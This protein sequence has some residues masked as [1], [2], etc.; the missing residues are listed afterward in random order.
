MTGQTLELTLPVTGMHCANCAVTIERVL[1]RLEGVGEVNVNLASE[2]AF[3][4]FDPTR[5]RQSEI[6][7]QIRKVGYDIAIARAELALERLSDGSEAQRL[8]QRLE[9]LPGVVSAAVNLAT[10]RVLLEYIP[11]AVSQREIRVEI[12]QAGFKTLEL[13]DALVDPEGEAR[14]RAVRRQRTLFLRGL[15]LTLPV[16]ALSMLADLGLLPSSITT[17]P[18]FGWSLLAL[19]TPVVFHVGWQF[20]EGSYQALLNRTANMDVHVAMGGL[21]AYGYS[22]AVVLGWVE[23][24]PFFE[25]AAVIITLIVLGRYLEARAKAQTSESIRALLG[26]TPKLARI[27]RAGREIEVPVDEVIVGD[28]VIVRPGEQ[29]PVDG[30][31]VDG[32]SS[33]DESMLTG[34]SIPVSKRAGDA[35]FA[36]SMN[37]LGAFRFEATKVGRDTALAQIVRLVQAAQASKAAIQQLAD[38]VSSVFVPAVLPVAALTFIA[39]YFFAPPSLEHPQFARAMINTVAVLVI[40]CPCAMGLATPTAV[41]VGLGKG[42]RM[43]ILFRSSDALERTG[44]VSTFV[45]DKTGT[46]TRGQPAVTQI[47]SNGTR[48]EIPELLRIAATAELGSE[49]PIGE[50]IVAEAMA[51]GLQPQPADR[52]EALPGGGVLA[53]L[54]AQR[55]LVGNVNLLQEQGVQLD[56][57]AD[58]IAKLEAG[59]ETVVIVAVDGKLS[60]ALSVADKLKEG[61]QQAVQELQRMGLRVMLMSGDNR[62]TAAAIANQ[63]GLSDPADLLAEILPAEKAEQVRALQADGTQVAMVGDG[64]NDAPALAEAAVGIAIG[65]GTDLAIAAAPV[66]L[67]SGDLRVLPRAIRLSRI[68]LRVI[69]QNLFWAFFYNTLLIPLAALG[70]LSPMM[71][72][73]AM[74]FSSIAVVT[75]SLRLRRMRI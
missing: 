58:Q 50:A 8:Q 14:A 65:S 10:E 29:L 67:M 43:G 20:L 34:E 53:Q 24:Q 22:L 56:G 15:V 54:G 48:L 35:V 31:V 32:R 71:A 4:S 9:A 5:S 3:V 75:N 41:T 13:E 1:R 69:K 47:F 70:Q 36:A 30:V 12:R 72:A 68:T 45:L 57:M 28:T 42:A 59:A 44:R 66:T 2:R 40:A 46:I 37:R 17:A 21:A 18:W 11:T 52:F 27:E 62:R 33:I 39:W 63:V 55:V 38:K 23:G 7:E 60:G 64:I 74:A 73:A 16:F 61:S 25:T 26:L 19:T 51:R 49:H 6:V